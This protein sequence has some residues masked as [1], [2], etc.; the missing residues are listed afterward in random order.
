M[1][2]VSAA[3]EIYLTRGNTAKLNINLRNNVIKQPYEVQSD[4]LVT[5]TVKRKYE[6]AEVL[7]EK[8]VTGSTKI[9]I[10]PED[11]KGLAFGRYEYDVQVTTANG[12]NYTPIAEKAFYITRGSV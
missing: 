5:F 11:T 8:K 7:I 2:F 3:Q 4:D 1:L 9:H 10:K 6:D 12:D